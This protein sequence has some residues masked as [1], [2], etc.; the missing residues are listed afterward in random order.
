MW[1]E[2]HLQQRN[3]CQNTQARQKPRPKYALI[4]AASYSPQCGWLAAPDAQAR[5]EHALVRFTLHSSGRCPTGAAGVTKDG[6]AAGLRAA[7]MM[8]RRRRTTDSPSVRPTAAR[9]SRSSRSSHHL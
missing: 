2:L 4:Q 6:T 9:H 1:Y 5:A 8:K 3:T 7:T